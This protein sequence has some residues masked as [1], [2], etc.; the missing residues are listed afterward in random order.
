MGSLYY[1]IDVW[2]FYFVTIFIFGGGGG[3]AQGA[4]RLQR[5]ALHARRKHTKK[6]AK[7]SNPNFEF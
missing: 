3:D 1:F 5:Y 7:F 6:V 4:L 2:E